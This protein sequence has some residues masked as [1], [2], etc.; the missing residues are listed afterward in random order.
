MNATSHFRTLVCLLLG[1]AGCGHRP[2]PATPAPASSGPA[3][4]GPGEPSP[5]H[6]ATAPE[7]GRESG[8]RAAERILAAAIHFD[9]DQ[10]MIRPEDQEILDQKLGILERSPSVRIRISGHADERGSDEY[11]LALGMRRAAAAARYF[12]QRGITASRLETASYGEEQPL[13]KGHDE[14]AWR[15]NRRAEFGTLGGELSPR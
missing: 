15:E 6:A 2:A 11:N 9:Y 1:A 14:A 8:A 3:L 10:A 7:E 4:D 5:T 12:A 13:E